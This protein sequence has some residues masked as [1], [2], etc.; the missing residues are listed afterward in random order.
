MKM[1][2][3]KG[4]G[5]SQYQCDAWLD[6]RGSISRQTMIKGGKG[7]K[8]HKS[9]ILFAFV[10]LVSSFLTAQDDY[11]LDYAKKS[12]QFQRDYGIGFSVK[13]LGVNRLDYKYKID[14]K[15][16]QP[17]PEEPQPI[18]PPGALIEPSEKL[19]KDI[20]ECFNKMLLDRLGVL[21]QEKIQEWYK[22]LDGINE[23]SAEISKTI[24]NAKESADKSNNDIQSILE[25]YKTEKAKLNDAITLLKKE[26]AGKKDP[27]KK[28]MESEIKEKEKKLNDLDNAQKGAEAK[29]QKLTEFKNSIKSKVNDQIKEIKKAI[30]D[31]SNFTDKGTEVLSTVEILKSMLETKEGGAIVIS[32]QAQPSVWRLKYVNEKYS[33]TQEDIKIESVS[34][35]QL[36]AA[37]ESHCEKRI[38]R[39]KFKGPKSI[40]AST[41]PFCTF[42]PHHEFQRILNPG[43]NESDSDAAP[44]Y[45]IDYKEKSKGGYGIATFWNAPALY[46]CSFLDVGF[47]W[48]VA[49]NVQKTLSTAINGLI[50]VYVKDPRSSVFFHFGAAFGLVEELAGNYE[51]KKTG[52]EENAMIPTIVKVKAALFISISFKL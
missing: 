42:L 6:Q 49:Y 40:T 33:I 29:Q 43:Y 51:I 38:I 20:I 10:L 4:A 2:D 21:G 24:G 50:G 23:S 25:N 5:Q 32:I 35:P 11:S 46:D 44:Q 8:N 18:S 13:I 28:Q 45:F 16:E 30:N 19:K 12:H 15:A 14:I 47:S 27:E 26:L 41:G 52:I 34:D 36:H 3:I 31:F 9:K 39:F 1:H 48:G 37:I 22:K 17:T 7:M